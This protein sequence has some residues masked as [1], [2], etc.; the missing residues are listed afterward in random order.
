M[1]CTSCFVGL[2]A[3]ITELLSLSH[4]E[5]GK[6]LPEY[7]SDFCKAVPRIM[8]CALHAALSS[9]KAAQYLSEVQ[10]IVDI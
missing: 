9:P 7:T 5:R 10:P 4:P 1:S 3:N 2:D 6:P 8:V